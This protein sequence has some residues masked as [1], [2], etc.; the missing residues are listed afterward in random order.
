[1]TEEAYLVVDA[2]QAGVGQAT[3]DEAKDAVEVATYST[4]KLDKGL[5]T[6][7]AGPGEPALDLSVCVFGVGGVEDLKK[8]LIE[9]IS[10]VE[11][12]IKLLDLRDLDRVLRIQFVA[13]LEQGPTATFDRSALFGLE[14]THLA[15]THLIES[16]LG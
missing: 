7:P 5:E 10:S 16:L 3:I 12:T 6:A 2:F 13:T 9:K 1:M 11:W 15:A 4:S 8:T 14:L